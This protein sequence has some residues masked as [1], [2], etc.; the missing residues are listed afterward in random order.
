LVL[1]HLP[2]WAKTIDLSQSKI[3]CLAKKDPLDIERH[4]PT[5]K[6]KSEK[7]LVD[8]A[9]KQGGQIPKQLLKA[10]IVIGLEGGLNKISNGLHSIGHHAAINA[11]GYK[12]A[13]LPKGR[14]WSLVVGHRFKGSIIWHWK[15]LRKFGKISWT[16]FTAHTILKDRLY[17]LDFPIRGHPNGIT[18]QKLMRTNCIF[19][20]A[21]DNYI[22]E[23]GHFRLPIVLELMPPR[24]MM[25]SQMFT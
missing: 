3:I 4:I 21:N 23:Y 15:L 5:Y 22:R 12:S 10:V 6:R 7:R 17:P 8:N 19:G 20:T 13:V 14:M 2:F 18:D 1:I 25:I 24:T 9:V 16:N 11:E